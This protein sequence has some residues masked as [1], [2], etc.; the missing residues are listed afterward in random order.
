M[1]G[2]KFGP[3]PKKGPTPQGIGFNLGVMIM[4]KKPGCPHRENGVGMSDIKGIKDVQ[5]K[6]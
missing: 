3:P 1:K 5:V 2:K 4:V 6:G